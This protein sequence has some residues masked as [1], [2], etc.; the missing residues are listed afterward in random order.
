MKE[1][2]DDWWKAPFTMNKTDW[3]WNWPGE[4]G[5]LWFGIMNS[6]KWAPIS[7]AN[8]DVEYIQ[9]RPNFVHH[10]TSGSYKPEARNKEGMLEA[11]RVFMKQVKQRI[12]GSSGGGIAPLDKA[13]IRLLE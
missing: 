12:M 2:L 10:Y 11:T 13:K 4:Q 1:L 7:Q 5:A 8:W 6:T 9:K 3:T